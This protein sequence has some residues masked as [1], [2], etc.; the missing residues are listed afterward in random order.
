MG[1]RGRGRRYSSEEEHPI[2]ATVP[3]WPEEVEIIESQRCQAEPV[4]EDEFMVELDLSGQN[5]NNPQKQITA[6]LNITKALV[7]VHYT[8]GLEHHSKDQKTGTGIDQKSR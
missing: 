8:A 6:G 3:Q 1:C 5:F 2:G 4:E 7:R